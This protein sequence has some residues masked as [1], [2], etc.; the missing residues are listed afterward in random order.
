MRVLEGHKT[1]AKGLGEI[2]F[3]GLKK[4][5]YQTNLFFC[6]VLYLVFYCLEGRKHQINK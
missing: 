6:F 1:F 4:Q 2:E 3:K 5:S